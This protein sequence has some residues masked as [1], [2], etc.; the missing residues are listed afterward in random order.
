ML[1]GCAEV[2]EGVYAMYRSSIDIILREFS[3][4]NTKSQYHSLVMIFIKRRLK[5]SI[6][7]L[8]LI[9]IILL[10]PDQKSENIATSF[11]N[12]SKKSTS[13][14]ENC[15]GKIIVDS[16]IQ[17]D[18]KIVQRFS[19]NKSCLRLFVEPKLVES[20]PTYQEFGM[21]VTSPEIDRN[22]PSL[23]DFHKI[24]DIGPLARKRPFKFAIFEEDVSNQFKHSRVKI[25]NLL[26]IQDLKDVDFVFMTDQ[27]LVRR[28]LL[29]VLAYGA[30][31]ILINISTSFRSLPF[32]EVLD[33]SKIVYRANWR[34]VPDLIDKLSWT[35]AF[36]RLGKRR[37]G[38]SVWNAYFSSMPKIL[39]TFV[40]I[41]TQQ[42]LGLPG[43]IFKLRSFS[44]FP[45][46]ITKHAYSIVIDFS[47]HGIRDDYSNDMAP[48]IW[49]PEFDYFYWN[50]A[51]N[52]F[53]RAPIVPPM[54]ETSR[55]GKPY[56]EMLNTLRVAINAKVQFIFP[57]KNSLHN[58]YLPL[59][60]IQTRSIFLFDD[61]TR[62]LDGTALLKGFRAWQENRDRLVGFVG[63]DLD[64]YLVPEMGKWHYIIQM[65]YTYNLPQTLKE[66][67][68]KE[69][70]CDDIF[71]NAMVQDLTDKPGLM[72]SYFKD[73]SCDEDV[74]N[75]DA[76][77]SIS[78]RDNHKVIRDQCLDMVYETYGY[79]PLRPGRFYV[80]TLERSFCRELNSAER[81]YGRYCYQKYSF[82]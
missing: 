79:M 51:F 12:Q 26:N 78:Q 58:R 4:S 28:R 81:D 44:R 53:I 20:T 59:D 37:Q 66:F 47:G 13:V 1:S 60:S 18:S 50:I 45:F 14:T 31:P 48:S 70:N 38:W 24:P 77:N 46:F 2:E 23:F 54:F 6:L 7:F 80:Q 67:V 32:A 74:C 57:P 5:L 34:T 30:I 71:L 64:Q 61:D 9:F 29:L 72:T 73:Y 75:L 25:L 19:K 10:Q 17:W 27:A 43:L 76:N 62:R 42:D 41:Y 36:E 22:I 52:P 33:W 49:N 15:L 69:L 82:N 8:M 21:K 40:A 63:R 56:F 3:I 55:G 65:H 68:D 35:N 16:N 39:D 11:P